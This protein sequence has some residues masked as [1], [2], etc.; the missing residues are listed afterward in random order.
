MRMCPKCK[1]FRVQTSVHVIS[2]YRCLSC[3]WIEIGDVKLNL[4]ALPPRQY[5]RP[6]LRSVWAYVVFSLVILGGGYLILAEVI[7]PAKYFALQDKVSQSFEK[8]DATGEIK[9]GPA[10]PGAPVIPN[11]STG[12]VPRLPEE[13]SSGAKSASLPQPEG[14]RVVANSKSKLYHL[15]GMKFYDKIPE[16]RRVIFTSEDAARRAGYRKSSR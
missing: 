8:N 1:S 7:T 6:L 5:L 11:P 10:T 4:Q 2:S 12:T 16:D 9:S 3:G 15:P 13:S 14:I